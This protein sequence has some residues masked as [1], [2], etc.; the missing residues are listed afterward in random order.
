M[1]HSSKN[2]FLF[3]RKLP[4]YPTFLFGNLESKKT[5]PEWCSSTFLYFLLNLLYPRIIILIED[6]S[7]S[8]LH[9]KH[10]HNLCR[11]LHTYGNNHFGISS[12][13]WHKPH[14]C[15]RTNYILALHLHYY[16]LSFEILRRTRPY[17][18]E[19]F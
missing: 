8:K 18:H 7:S 17:N 3:G 13:H 5:F 10:Q 12:M 19:G 14:I 15:W 6:F 16:E 9:D 4:F 1:S 2:F 11:L